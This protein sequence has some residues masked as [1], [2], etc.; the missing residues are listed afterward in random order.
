MSLDL[1]YV[2][3]S[4]ILRLVGVW[5]PYLSSKFVFPSTHSQT[6]KGGASYFAGISYLNLNFDKVKRLEEPTQFNPLNA[7]LNPIRHLLVLV[8]ARHIVHHSRI[9]VNQ[10]SPFLVKPPRHDEPQDQ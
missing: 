3:L 8:G 5:L 6:V 4:L 7:E 2:F 1:A 10:Y 9:R